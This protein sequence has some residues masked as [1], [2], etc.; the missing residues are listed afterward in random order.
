LVHGSKNFGGFG[1]ELGSR[2]QHGT[3]SARGKRHSSKASE[4]IAINAFI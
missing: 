4:R 1:R 2:R 3:C